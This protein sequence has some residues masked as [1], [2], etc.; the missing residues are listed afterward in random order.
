MNGSL[1]KQAEKVAA[2]A[3]RL[4][5][6]TKLPVELRDE[7]LSTVSARRLLRDIGKKARPD[8]AIAAALI[9]QTCLDENSDRFQRG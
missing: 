2:F 9:L 6:H 3:R 7:R 4:G 1:G 8:D 5:E